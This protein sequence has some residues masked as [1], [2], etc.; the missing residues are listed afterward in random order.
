MNHLTSFLSQQTTSLKV[1]GVTTLADARTLCEMGVPA[2]GVNYWPNSKRYVEQ[3]KASEFLQEVGG[4]ILRVGVF[5]NAEPQ[6]PLS[7]V[8]RGDLDL[9]QFHGDETEAYCKIFQ[10]EGVP[11]I[12]AFGVKNRESLKHFKDGGAAAALLDTHAP[13]LYGG[14]GDCFDW[15]LA[16]AF[17]SDHSTLPIL[18]AGGIT[19]ENAAEATKVVRPA[20]LDVATGAESRPGVKDFSKV[21]R[22]LEAIR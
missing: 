16:K 20:A 19:A 11:Y 15:D 17:Q 18:L 8:E 7:L 21:A 2:L 4:Q 5:V 12:R 9:V 6:L 3:Q 1:C 14:T 13:G 10:Q 22:L